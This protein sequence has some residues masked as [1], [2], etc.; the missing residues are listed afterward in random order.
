MKKI[1]RIVWISALSGLAFLA[2]C[3]GSR[4]LSKWERKKLLDERAAIEKTLAETPAVDSISM[5][6][7]ETQAKRYDLMNKI[8]SI[9][10]KLG[11]DVDVARNVRRRELQLRIDSIYVEINKANYACIYGSPEMLEGRDE[12]YN[13]F[14][15]NQFGALDAELKK[16]KADLEAFELTDETYRAQRRQEL[17]EQLELLR[18]TIEER[19]GARVYGSPEVIQE[20]R[21]ETQRLR[22]EAD[23]LQ[24]EIKTLE[25]RLQEAE[26]RKLDSIQRKKELQQK[27]DSIRQTRRDDPK[28]VVYGPPPMSQQLIQRREE[29]DRRC[30]QLQQEM[31]SLEAIITSRDSMGASGSPE[32]MEE[33]GKVTDSLRNEWNKKDLELSRLKHERKARGL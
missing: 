19:E 33:Y 30:K 4:G 31:E 8:D 29:I 2:A 13:A 9:N 5:S 17:E 11:E 16:A 18:N 3:C 27:R 22:Q 1:I 10:F 14:K 25:E 28:G 26:Q 20:Y 23:S 32:E 15:A 7:A 6:F 21:K 24:R 12:E